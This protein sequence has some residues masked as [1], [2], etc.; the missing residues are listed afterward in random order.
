MNIEKL[1]KALGKDFT[2]E[3]ILFLKDNNMLD[4]FISKTE[5]KHNI[6]QPEVK[7]E[8][9]EIDLKENADDEYK[10][11]DEDEIVEFFQASF[12]ESRRYDNM[13]TD[14][15]MTN[16]DLIDNWRYFLELDYEGTTNDFQ[17]EVSVLKNFINEYE[18]TQI[19]MGTMFERFI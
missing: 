1:K 2:N 15:L 16:R 9:E 5:E 10:I 11:W 8:Y 12:R 13:I 17:N 6:N 14:D 19:N 4:D 3:I 7:Q 18:K